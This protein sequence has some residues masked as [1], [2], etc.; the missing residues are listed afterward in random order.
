[1][2]GFVLSRDGAIRLR[3][4]SGLIAAVLTGVALTASGVASAT[5]PDSIKLTGPKSA[6]I[7]TS[8]FIKIEA[9]GN[10]Q[11]N[12]LRYY[13]DAKRCVSTDWAERRYGNWMSLGGSR[14]FSGPKLLKTGFPEF[15]QRRGIHHLCAFLINPQA[16]AHPNS[17][18]A[19]QTYAHASFTWTE[20]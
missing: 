3:A 2:R 19:D 11:N 5:R 16:L 9:Y 7:N 6:R 14:T 15:A 20:K 12:L 18:Q 10:S 17:E 1:M 13:A 8:I 4:R